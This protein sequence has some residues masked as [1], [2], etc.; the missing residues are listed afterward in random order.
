MIVITRVAGTKGTAWIEGVGAEVRIADAN[1]TRTVP[2]GADLPTY[3]PEPLPPGV[4]HSAYDYMIAHG[5]DLGPYTCLARVFRDLIL[6]E[7]I[8]D[9]PRPATFADGVAGMEVLDAVRLSARTGGAWVPINPR[10]D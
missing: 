5:L 4:L 7:P 2:V 9:D 10:V 1:G 8:A 6:G 3:P